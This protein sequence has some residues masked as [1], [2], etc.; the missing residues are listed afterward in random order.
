M[1]L[2]DYHISYFSM[3][4]QTLVSQGPLIIEASRWYSVIHTTLG[5]TPLD[6]WSASPR[7]LYLTTHKTHN[8]QTSIPPAGL[9][10]TILASERQ[11]TDTFAR[12]RESA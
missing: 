12:P 9:G 5:R 8:R 6:E 10:L 2:Y 1:E 7:D 3:T 11:Q 4:Q